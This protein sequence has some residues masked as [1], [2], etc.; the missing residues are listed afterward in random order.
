MAPDRA[1]AILAEGQKLAAAHRRQRMWW[2]SAGIAA[3]ASVVGGLGWVS[4]RDPA[5]PIA[6]S[7]VRLPALQ[8]SVMEFSADPG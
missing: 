7:G 4:L 6:A 3:A 2:R 1:A 5:E 8:E